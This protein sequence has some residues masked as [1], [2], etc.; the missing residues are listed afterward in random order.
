MSAEEVEAFRRS[1][2]GADAVAL[3]RWDDAAKEPG[4]AVPGFEDYV[5]TFAEVLA[6][7]S[8]DSP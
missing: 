2:H 5:P 8:R 3:R 6:A 4:L 1:P 7:G